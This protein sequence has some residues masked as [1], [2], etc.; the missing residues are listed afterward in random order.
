MS[1]LHLPHWNLHLPAWHWP[2]WASLPRQ[3][4]RERNHDM[5][6]HW[7]LA[8]IAFAVIVAV[9]LVSALILSRANPALTPLQ[10]PVTSAVAAQAV[11]FDEFAEAKA[12][13][14]VEELPPQ[15]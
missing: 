14:I 3:E 11:E 6:R 5:L 13:A 10:M 12:A 15:F 2:A 8:A 7:R 1:Q 9:A 4:A